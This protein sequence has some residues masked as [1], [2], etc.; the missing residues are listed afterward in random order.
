L[1]LAS[2]LAAPANRKYVVEVLARRRGQDAGSQV[3]TTPLDGTPMDHCG[4]V[5]RAFGISSDDLDLN[6]QGRLGPTQARNLRRSGYNN[7]AAAL[8]LGLG[9]GA[10]LR[11][12]VHKPLVPAQWI[13]ASLLF[14]AGLAAGMVHFRKTHRAAAKGVVE[15]LTGPVEVRSRGQ[16]GW[17]LTVTGRSFRL[18][19]RPWQLHNGATYHVYVAPGVNGIVGMEPVGPT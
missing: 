1:H 18:P 12:I 10:I 16:A 19:V 14:A 4:E 8:V 13:T 9:L 7:L 3:K 11:W 6:R 17:W 5:L 15:C 2:R